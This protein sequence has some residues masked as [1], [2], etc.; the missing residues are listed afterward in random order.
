MLRGH[1]EGGSRR[2]IKK[3]GCKTTHKGAMALAVVHVEETG[4]RPRLHSRSSVI[5]L[6]PLPV[7]R[8]E[9]SGFG[10]CKRLVEAQRLHHK[11]RHYD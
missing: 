9:R 5:K 1:G 10:R 8:I 2:R 7:K 3:P 11:G 6:R 4:E